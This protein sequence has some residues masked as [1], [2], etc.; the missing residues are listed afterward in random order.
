M[1]DYLRFIFI[2]NKGQFSEL[3]V[4]A[5]DRIYFIQSLS[6]SHTLDGMGAP[7]IMHTPVLL[8]LFQSFIYS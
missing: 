3:C 2:S 7:L 4:S 6:Y 8:N 5:L 1:Y